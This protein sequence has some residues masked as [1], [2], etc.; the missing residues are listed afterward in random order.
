MVIRNTKDVSMTGA[1]ATLIVGDGEDIVY[2]STTETIPANGS[3]TYK[4]NFKEYAD[5]PVV[6]NIAAPVRVHMEW[7]N[8]ERTYALDNLNLLLQQSPNAL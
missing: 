2:A 3:A 1:K 4:F 7:S 6:I 5:F 8:K